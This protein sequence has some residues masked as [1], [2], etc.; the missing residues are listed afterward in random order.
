MPADARPSPPMSEARRQHVHGKVHPQDRPATVLDLL[1]HGLPG[2]LL[3][4]AAFA[5]ATLLIVAF[6]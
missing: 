5:V 3:V 1:M 2:A 6:S 4:G